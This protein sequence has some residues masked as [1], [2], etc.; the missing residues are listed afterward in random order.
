M[1]P[2]LSGTPSPRF[3]KLVTEDAAIRKAAEH[4][5]IRTL[6]DTYEKPYGDLHIEREGA[7]QYVY[8]WD[9]F[10]TEKKTL[11]VTINGEAV[12]GLALAYPEK[13][14]RREYLQQIQNTLTEMEKNKALDSKL[15]KVRQLTA[16]LFNIYTNLYNHKVRNPDYSD[17]VGQVFHHF[18]LDMYLDFRASLGEV[19]DALKE[20]PA[21]LK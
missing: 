7:G 21:D 12:L 5:T 9:Q 13:H 2:V 19:L 16:R 18:V 4:P 1:V 14:Q 17:G 20:K 11:S 15:S 3:G 8:Y 6:I 10:A